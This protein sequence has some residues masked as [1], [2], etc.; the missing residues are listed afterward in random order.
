MRTEID[1]NESKHFFKA[2]FDRSEI[3]LSVK[4]FITKNNIRQTK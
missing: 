2:N 3:A 4:T 1:L